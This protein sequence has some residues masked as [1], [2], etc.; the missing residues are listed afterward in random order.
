[1]CSITSER[2]SSWLCKQLIHTC[3]CL[4]V[5]LLTGGWKANE[6]EAP[7]LF[8]VPAPLLETPSAAKASHNLDL[9][10][11]GLYMSVTSN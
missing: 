8:V 1:M 6:G 9:T 4:G 7:C 3:A 2:D 10:S 11:S 5:L